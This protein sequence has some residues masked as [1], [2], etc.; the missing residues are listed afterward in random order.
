MLTLLIYRSD[1]DAEGCSQ[2]GVDLVKLHELVHCHSLL[3]KFLY[4]RGKDIQTT[5]N[6]IRSVPDTEEK[7]NRS[8]E[9][10][11]VM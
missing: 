11:S 6:K 1:I 9:P 10:F 3:H 2:C 7:V 8:F 4:P 5:I